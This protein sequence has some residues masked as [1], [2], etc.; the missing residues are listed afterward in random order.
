M[1]SN[2]NIKRSMYHRKMQF[3]NYSHSVIE[4]S[5]IKVLKNSKKLCLNL[6]IF[7]HLKIIFH[8]SYEIA[9]YN[10]W[11]ELAPTN[12]H[13]LFVPIL[14]IRCKVQFHRMDAIVFSNVWIYAD[15]NLNMARILNE[16]FIYLN[17]LQK[18]RETPPK[19]VG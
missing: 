8:P 13:C 5:F 14:T 9:P 11:L 10:K 15:F 7:T 16:T 1:K 2:F 17:G 12:R 4:M 6:Y 3:K 19:M 18:P